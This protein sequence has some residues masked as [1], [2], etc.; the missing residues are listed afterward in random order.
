VEAAL[1][2]EIRDGLASATGVDLVPAAWDLAVVQAMVGVLGPAQMR[3]VARA[4]MVDS[5]GGP[6]LGNLLAT[7]LR[8]FG[9]SPG[10][11]LG[12][13]GRAFGHVTV[14]CGTLRVTGGEVGASRLA[15]EGMD[16]WLAR[17]EYLDAIAAAMEAVF[18]VCRVTGRVSVEPGPSGGRFEARWTPTG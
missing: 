1:P 4:A 15:L 16:P 9:A 14:D 5:L 3:R 17:P 11:L 2:R 7:G 12:W 6:L 13:S 10:S 8:L 18:D